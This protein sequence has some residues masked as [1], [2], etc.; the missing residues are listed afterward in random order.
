[1][2]CA[3]STMVL[4]TLTPTVRPQGAGPGFSEDSFNDRN[5]LVW[6]LPIGPNVPGVLSK[7]PKV[8]EGWSQPTSGVPSQYASQHLAQNWKRYVLLC[9]CGV[10]VCHGWVVCLCSRCFICSQC[11]ATAGLSVGARV[12]LCWWWCRAC[13]SEARW[14]NREVSLSSAEVRQSHS[15]ELASV[16]TVPRS[17]S[18]FNVVQTGLKVQQSATSASRA[19]VRNATR[20][21]HDH[22]TRTMSQGDVQKARSGERLSHVGEVCDRAHVRSYQQVIPFLPPAGVGGSVYIDKVVS[23]E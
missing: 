13:F 10:T 12:L 18:V 3:V 1:M 22:R 11:L 7:G 23:H 19:V 8:R 6:L 4:L 20:K 16:P 15:Q 9:S 21:E 14:R 17:C 5:A 2:V